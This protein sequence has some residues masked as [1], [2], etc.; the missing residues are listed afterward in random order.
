MMELRVGET[1][2][3]PKIINQYKLTVSYMHGDAD[4]ES[5]ETFFFTKKEERGLKRYIEIAERAKYDS[6]RDELNSLSGEIESIKCGLIVM[7][8]RWEGNLCRPT[9]EELTWFNEN[10]VEHEVEIE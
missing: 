9:I 1:I 10:G 6:S 8:A 5:R 2:D 3:R 4:G 7:D